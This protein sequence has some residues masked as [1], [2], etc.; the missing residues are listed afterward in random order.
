M[1]AF[2]M[3]LVPKSDRVE[4]IAADPSGH[5]IWINLTKECCRSGDWV[6]RIHSFSNLGCNDKRLTFVGTSSEDSLT[7]TPGDD[8]IHLGPGDDTVQAGDGSD[9]VCG[10]TGN[11]TLLGGGGDDTLLGQ[12]GDDSLNGESG[13]DACD[14]GLGIDE[15]A[16]CEFLAGIP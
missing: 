13:D 8:V 11:D 1:I 9:T 14:G 5:A 4:G 12:D 16:E 15:A 10:G 3:G 2:D 7:T 6:Y